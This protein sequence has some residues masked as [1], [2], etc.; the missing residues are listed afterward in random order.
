MPIWYHRLLTGP[1]EGFH[2]LAATTRS[3][4][5]WGL[6]AEVQRYRRHYE[7]QRE[8]QL[9]IERLE[10]EH[11]L[12]THQLAAGQRR[13]EAAQ[14]PGQVRRLECLGEWGNWKQLAKRGRA[15]YGLGSPF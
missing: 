8:L 12:I 14:A 4:D 6:D 10:G 5:D 11:A 1:T 2:D 9:E 3:L 7:R 15:R 13:L